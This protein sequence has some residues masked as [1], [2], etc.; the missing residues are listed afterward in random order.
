MGSV[1]GPGFD[2]RRLHFLILLIELLGSDRESALPSQSSAPDGGLVIWKPRGPTS[3]ATIDQVQERLGVG[4]LGHCGTLD[5]LASGVLVI[6]GG[7][8]RRFQELLTIHDKSYEA[9]IW[10]GVCSESEDAEGPL[11]CPYPRNEWPTSDL[12]AHTLDGFLGQQSQTPPVHSAVRVG[13]RRSYERAR[14]GDRTPPPSR[15]VVFHSLS[16]LELD[17]PRLR[18]SIECSRG[19]YIRSLAR[20]LGRSVGCPASLMALRRTSSGVHSLTDAVLPDRVVSSDWLSLEQLLDQI[21]RVEVDTHQA[22]CLGHGQFLSLDELEHGQVAVD[23]PIEGDL[24]VVWC[25]GV[26]RGI[27][28]VVDGVLRPKRWLPERGLDRVPDLA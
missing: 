21:H 11:S 12:I 6:I 8:G 22:V 27:A 7:S 5:P 17:G 25:Q 3:R 4:G 1:S 28:R 9:T 26:V 15:E 16:M 20:D 23:S 10:F 18:L 24:R 14:M 13:R 19:T 2:S